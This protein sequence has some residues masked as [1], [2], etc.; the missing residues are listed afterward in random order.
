MRRENGE[1]VGVCGGEEIE[2]GWRGKSCG[3][4][5]MRENER[6][7]F[8]EDERERVGEQLKLKIFKFPIIRESFTRST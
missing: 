2:V 3:L 1:M 8:M 7:G 6:G 5:W 4:V